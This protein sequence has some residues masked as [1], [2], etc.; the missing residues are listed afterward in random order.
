MSFQERLA[1]IVEANAGKAIA[2]FKKVGAAA[3]EAETSVDGGA[4]GLARFGIA[5]Q[6][7][8]NLLKGGLAIGGAAAASAIVKFAVDGVTAFVELTGE[9]RT[10]QRVSGASAEDA[11]KLVAVFHVLGIDGDAAAKAVFKLAVNIGT[12][13][14]AFAE[15]GITVAKLR[16]GNVDLVGTILNIGDAYKATGDATKRADLVAAAFGARQGQVLQPLLGKTRQEIEAIFKA[17]EGHGLIFSQ[18]QIDKGKEFTLATRELG[19]AFKGIQ[20]A[21]GEQLVPFLTDLAIVITKVIDATHGQIGKGFIGLL[22]LTNAPLLAVA[23]GLHLITG[24]EVDAAKAAA[25]TVAAI[26][27]QTADYDLL[28]KALLTATD[29]QHSY[30]AAGRSEEAAKRTLTKATADYNKLLKEGA[31]DAKKVADATVSLAEATRSVGHAQR[32]QT[33]SQGEYNEALAAFNIL[34]TDTARDKL[35]DASNNLADA[36]DNVADAQDRANKAAKDLADAKAGDPDYQTK[37]ATAKQ[38]VADA[39]QGIADAEYNL[40]KASLANIAAHDAETK[41]LSDK[42]DQAERLIADNLVLIAQHPELQA[43]LGPQTNDLIGAA[44]AYAFPQLALGGATAPPPPPPPPLPPAP[45][46]GGGQ[47]TVGKVGSVVVNITKAVTDPASIARD[48]V[49]HLGL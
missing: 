38:S 9:I 32:E 42:A 30:E 43:V 12:G 19:E 47:S 36:N 26:E 41:A 13:N 24:N 8:T 18:D 21:A 17:A 3:K 46:G 11:S 4:K 39:T 6:T 7:A 2:E 28:N 16:N 37:L 44:P 29:A 1:I 45:P 33:K 20:V 40:G 49:W 31:V 48:I 25:A 14:K 15:S 5:G 22:G 27:Q 34:G 10:F 35:T 23:Y